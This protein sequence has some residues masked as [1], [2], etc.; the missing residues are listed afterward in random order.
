VDNGWALAAGSAPPI[1]CAMTSPNT[2]PTKLVMAL[3][4]TGLVSSALA[5][6]RHSCTGRDA[7]QAVS[8]ATS[9]SCTDTLTL[10]YASSIDVSSEPLMLVEFVGCGCSSTLVEARVAGSS[11][12]VEEAALML[13]ESARRRDDCDDFAATA[14]GRCAVGCLVHRARRAGD[15][16]KGKVRRHGSRS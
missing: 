5:Y 12:L 13:L 7:C 8:T 16:S 3:V 14:H 11:T 1:F 4:R 2:K 6:I 9:A 15:G 10:W